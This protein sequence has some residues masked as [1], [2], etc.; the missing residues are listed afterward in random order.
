MQEASM[1]TA[2]SNI[3]G[4]TLQVIIIYSTCCYF[5]LLLLLMSSCHYINLKAQLWASLSS[6]VGISNDGSARICFTASLISLGPV[7]VYK[8][9]Y[10]HL[11][12]H[13]KALMH[14]TLHHGY[15]YRLDRHPPRS[16]CI[17]AAIPLI[18]RGWLDDRWCKLNGHGQYANFCSNK[19]WRCWLCKPKISMGERMHNE[20]RMYESSTYDRR[21]SRAPSQLLSFFCP[22]LYMYKLLLLS[23]DFVCLFF[24]WLS[25]ELAFFFWPSSELAFFF[26]SVVNI[27]VVDCNCS[28]CYLLHRH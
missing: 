27:S 7:V 22:V 11:H 13:S 2:S 23:A 15:T 12:M 26:I 10:I 20:L 3:G 28:L 5:H 17:A 8:Y 6:E 24:F 25:A 4:L 21:Q 9:K 19:E 16:A 18:S 1:Q 14:I